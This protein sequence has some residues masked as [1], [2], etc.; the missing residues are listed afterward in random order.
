MVALLISTMFLSAILGRGSGRRMQLQYTLPASV[1]TGDMVSTRLELT[2]SSG[3]PVMLAR[4]ETAPP[5]S[6]D[7]TPNGLQLQ[8]GSLQYEMPLLRSS[9]SVVWQQRWQSRRRGVYR[10]PPPRLGSVDP[11]GLFEHLK[12]QGDAQETLVLPRPVR[13]ERLGLWSGASASSPQ[14]PRTMPTTDAAELHGIRPWHPGEAVRRVHWKSTAR[15]GQ[16]HIVEWEEHPA[17][18]LSVLLDTSHAALVG[19][20]D[21]N[22]F[23]ASIVFVASMAAYVLESGYRFQLFCWQEEKNQPRLITEDLRSPAALH[24]VLQTLA[25]LQPT[26]A[27]GTAIDDLARVAAPALLDGA[28][29]VASSRAPFEAA[30]QILQGSSQNTLVVA[31]LLDAASF[32]SS[33]NAAGYAARPQA[34]V[35]LVQR[36]EAPAA[37]LEQPF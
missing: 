37:V 4:L 14:A 31:L 3:W 2:N 36:G 19:D 28:I 23:E 29:V 12:P 17:G 9:E 27:K 1:M 20:E 11:L 30:Q 15:T 21:D 33:G 8:W 25:R 35:R 13:V 24:G 18:D 34:G 10:W 32:N 26:S 7:N 22:S 16:L 6:A 5:Q